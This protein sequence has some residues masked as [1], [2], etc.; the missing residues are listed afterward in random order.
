M[1]ALAISSASRTCVDRLRTHAA[2]TELP[3]PIRVRLYQIIDVIEE[4]GQFGRSADHL[5]TTRSML[6]DEYGFSKS[7]APASELNELRLA[8]VA[9]SERAE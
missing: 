8:L 4:T 2:N 9:M 3:D 7:D 1:S 6:L 5:E